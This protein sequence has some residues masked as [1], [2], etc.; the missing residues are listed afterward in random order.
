MPQYVTSASSFPFGSYWN[1]RCFQS[2]QDGFGVHG[3]PANLPYVPFTLTAFSHAHIHPIVFPNRVSPASSVR[4]KR[5]K[6]S[7]H[8]NYHG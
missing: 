7:D 3:N 8:R 2:V 4:I 1:N 5:V 6:S